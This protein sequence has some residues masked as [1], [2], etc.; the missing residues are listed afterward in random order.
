MKDKRPG[1]GEEDRDG[2]GTLQSNK[3]L[4]AGFGG[5]HG[6]STESE[7]TGAEGGGC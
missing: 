4:G 5:G 6:A 7:S 2:S 1:E 3:I